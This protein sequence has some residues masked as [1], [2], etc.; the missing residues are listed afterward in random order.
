[1]TDSIVSGQIEVAGTKSI[2]IQTAPSTELKGNPIREPKVEKK[3]G[4]TPVRE[5]NKGEDSNTGNLSQDP[6]GANITTSTKHRNGE[7]NKSLSG[8]LEI[9]KGSGIHTKGVFP[10]IQKRRQRKE[11]VRKTENLT[12]LGLK[13]RGNRIYREI[14]G[15]IKRKH[16]RINTSKTR[17]MVQSNIHNSEASLE[18]EENIGCECNEQG[19]TNDSFQDVWNRSSERLDKEM[20]LGNKF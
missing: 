19:N 4:K 2:N 15:R 11:I 6:N 1:S 18:M 16:N 13:R 17:Q 9:G 14:G 7:K 10:S 8:D 12:V 20:R 3:G 5:Q